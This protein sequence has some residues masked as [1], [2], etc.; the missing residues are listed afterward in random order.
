MFRKVAALAALALIP[1][2]TGCGSSTSSQPTKT[3]T[4]AASSASPAPST[5]TPSV[6]PADAQTSAADESDPLALK[7]FGG[8]VKVADHVTITLGVPKTAATYSDLDNSDD[9]DGYWLGAYD[10]TE[11]GGVVEIPVTI[12]NDKDGAPFDA[13]MGMGFSSSAGEYS[14]SAQLQG[15]DAPV[16]PG[17]TMKALLVAGATKSGQVTITVQDAAMSIAGIFSNEPA[18]QEP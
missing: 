2:M 11:S 6:A 9:S 15:A 3:V 7:K 17:R 4:V 8:S 16:Q 10:A 12:T 1:A 18:G 5:A 13:S 14:T